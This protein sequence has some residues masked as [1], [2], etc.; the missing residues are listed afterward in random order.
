MNSGHSPSEGLEQSDVGAPSRRYLII[1]NKTLV[2]PGLEQ[3]VHECVAAGPCEFHVLVP[4][5]STPTI[6]AVDPMGLIDLRLHQPTNDYYADVRHEAE[7]RLDHFRETFARQG[8]LITGEVGCSDP[9]AAARNVVERL[10]F[11]EIIVSTLPPGVSRW[12]KMDLVNRVQRA[13]ELRVTSLVQ[14]DTLVG[15]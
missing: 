11:D 15:A 9:L 12:L 13:F 7:E 1:A 14:Q 8:V 10:L 5:A 3:L 2:S 4:Q 6:Y